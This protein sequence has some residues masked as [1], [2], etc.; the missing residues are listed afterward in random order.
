MRLNVPY[1][2]EREL[3]EIAKVLSTGY[4]TQGPKTVEFEWKV[5]EYIGCKYA[6][7]MSSCTT[8]LH[9]SL[10]VLDVKPGDEVLVADFTFPATANVVV[11][12][13]AIPVLVDIDLDTFTVNVDDLR[14]K[15]T[16]KTKAIIPVDAFGCAADFD[17]IQKIAAAHNLPVIEDAATA[18]GTK[19][20]DRF[21]G[22]LT[23]LGC[24]SFHP[25]KVITT[26]EGGMITTN[27]DKLAERIKLLRSHGGVR[28]GSWYRFEE[29]GFNYRLSDILSAIGVA[30]MEKLAKLVEHKQRLAA[31]LSKRLAQIPGIRVPVEPKWGGHIYQSY[32]I[33]LD[34]G[35]NRDTIVEKMRVHGIETTL[36]TYALHDQ[37]FFQRTF[38]YKS[39]QLPNSHA[40][41]TRTITLPLY[42]QMDESDLDQVADTLNAIL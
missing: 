1:T 42:P 14:H 36:G 7:A 35:L 8:A 11:Q 23:T 20:Y 16:P 17:A 29:A 10:V 21:C 41:F 27:D 30:Q 34:E 6:F 26:G 4:F 9:L 3:E 32:V 38:G 19:Y 37:P 22:N 12:L 28:T 25:R 5:A 31:S 15:I 33:L 18:I 40:A 2:D 39:G 13:G 24:F